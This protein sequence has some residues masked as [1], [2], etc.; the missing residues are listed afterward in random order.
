[1]DPTESVTMM[2]AAGDPEAPPTG[3]PLVELKT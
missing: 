3:K 2:N 1:M